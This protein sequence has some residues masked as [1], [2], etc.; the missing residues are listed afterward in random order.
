[1]LWYAQLIGYPV[2]MFG[3]RLWYAQLIKQS[4]HV[5]RNVLTSSG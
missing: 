3:L 5:L 1:M 4:H 2:K